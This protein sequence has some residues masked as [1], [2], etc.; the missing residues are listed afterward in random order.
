MK[1]ALLLSEV[2]DLTMGQ[3]PPSS[4][5]NSDGKGLPFFQGK[6]EF[7]S[8]YPIPVKWCS[9]P[10]KIAEAGDILMSVRAPV[11]PTNLADQKC[12]IGRGIAAIR[13][14]SNKYNTNF[15]L[16]F[17]RS[18]ENILAQT[19]VGS[20]FA[21]I[22]RNDIS[23]IKVPDIPLPEQRRIADLLT[24]AEAA[25]TKRCEAIRLADEFLKAVF[26]E[27]FGDP[28]RNEKGWEVKKFSDIFNSIRYGTGSP[29]E[30][31]EKGI[32]FIRA[33]NIKKGTVVEEGLK[34]ISEKESLKIEKCRLKAGNL[35]LVRSGVNAGDCGLIPIKYDGAFAAY[36]LIIELPFHKAVFYN[37]LINSSFGRRMIG[38][39]KR[40]A[41]QPHLN[42][43]QVGNLAFI[44]PPAPL[45]QKF[46]D[47]VN[48]A[49]KLKDRQS[50]SEKHLEN[51]I[52]VLMQ[53]AF[54]T[55]EEA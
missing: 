24:R 9:E 16:L 10:T 47:T 2:A 55:R 21:A 37:H 36:D 40:R 22:N 50:E 42:S 49:E 15:L 31:I 28:V 34:F 19:G 14:K 38:P 52:G 18:I 46:T 12:C 17:L 26:L 1:Q 41:G 48:N 5:Y 44:C 20:T 53:R 3:S 4:T 23:K 29:P 35:I 6:A 54:E 13:C 25:L 43:N 8:L 33:T 39:L 51:L 7:G 45:Q 27:M 30:Y 11:G 32:P